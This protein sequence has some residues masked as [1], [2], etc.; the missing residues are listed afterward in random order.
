[1][2]TL[3]IL[4]I[5]LVS[6]LLLSLTVAIFMFDNYYSGVSRFNG[7]KRIIRILSDEARDLLRENYEIN[8]KMYFQYYHCVNVAIYDWD[9]QNKG[10]LSSIKMSDYEVKFEQ[11]L[12]SSCK[13]GLMKYIVDRVYVNHLSLWNDKIGPKYLYNGGYLELIKRADAY[14]PGFP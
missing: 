5:I 9:D 4:A 8:N 1:M 13:T 12:D 10:V 11:L 3:N 2:K 14:N 7:D 6:A